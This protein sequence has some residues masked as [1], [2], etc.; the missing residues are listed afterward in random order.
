MWKK[1][2]N[3]LIDV[4]FEIKKLVIPDKKS[5]WGSTFVVILVSIALSVLIG[6]FDFIISKGLIM[7][8]R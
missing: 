1:L 8:T 7:I 4:K 2:K 5:L 6:L 3:Y